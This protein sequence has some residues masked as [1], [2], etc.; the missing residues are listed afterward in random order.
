MSD[1]E[2]I[3]R[4]VCSA[5][6]TVAAEI[7]ALRSRCEAAEAEVERLRVLVTTSDPFKVDVAQNERN[8]AFKVANSEIA[9]RK[10]AEARSERLEARVNVLS[11]GF[12]NASCHVEDVGWC[13]CGSLGNL[14]CDEWCAAARATLADEG[15]GK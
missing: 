14:P 9:A 10:A 13:A 2:L 1:E 4:T 8:A 5:Y 11:D 12:R 3:M 15:G 6:P 7:A